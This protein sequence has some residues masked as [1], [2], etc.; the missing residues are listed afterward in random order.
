MCLFDLVDK[1]VRVIFVS[2]LS[3]GWLFVTRSRV[4]LIDESLT[5]A[6]RDSAARQVLASLVD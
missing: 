1:G 6:D 4:L 3:E 2:V 5:P